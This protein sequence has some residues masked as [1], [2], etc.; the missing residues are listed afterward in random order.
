[1]QLSLAVRWP[2]CSIPEPRCAAYL[3][4]AMP[5]MVT[6]RRRHAAAAR[7]HQVRASA[8]APADLGQAY[9]HCKEITSEFAKT[10]YF[11]TAFQPED[12]AKSIYAIYAWCRL[13]DETIDGVADQ[14][15]KS[16]TRSDE[17]APCCRIVRGA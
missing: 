15:R 8:A 9:D 13:L 11:A 5:L 1:M 3:R 14:H 10:F 16:L 7:V 6:R 2:R 4:R 17:V 12:K